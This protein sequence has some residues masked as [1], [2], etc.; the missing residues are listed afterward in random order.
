MWPI[1]DAN[2]SDREHRIDCTARLLKLFEEDDMD[3]CDV[4]DLHPEVRAAM[5]RAGIAIAEPDR[6]QD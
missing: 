1:I 5:R 6:Y 2:I 3:T 4:A